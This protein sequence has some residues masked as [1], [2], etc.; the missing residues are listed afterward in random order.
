MKKERQDCNITIFQCPNEAMDLGMG[1]K[2]P[3]KGLIQSL[4]SFSQ[5][6][7]KK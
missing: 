5:P 6:V 1:P 7:S 2:T 3:A 4:A